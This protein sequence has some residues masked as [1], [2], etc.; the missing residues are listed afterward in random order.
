[1]TNDELRLNAIAAFKSLPNGFEVIRAKVVP[2]NG[3][4]Q[5]E[6]GLPTPLVWLNFLD[7]TQQPQ[8]LIF[9][10]DVDE[11]Q[12]VEN[13]IL[14]R[15]RSSS[16]SIENKITV[17][18]VSGLL[19]GT[20]TGVINRNYF[21]G[22]TYNH[23]QFYVLSA[24]GRL[25][26]MKNL[27]REV[28]DPYKFLS[29][30][31]AQDSLI[32]KGREDQI[33][34]L[35]LYIYEHRIVVVNGEASVGKTSLL[36]AGVIPHLLDKG[37]MA[38]KIQEYTNPV[39]VITQVL[40]SQQEGLQIPLPDTLTLPNLIH[41]ITSA[42]EGTLV[43]VLDQF[44]LLF[45]SSIS[46]EQR[47][48][49]IDELAICLREIPSQLLRL[50]IAIRSEA[51]T[52]LWE[53]QE[54][55]PELLRCQVQL[56]ALDRAN[57]A[58]A[59]REPLRVVE[60]RV[61]FYDDVVERLL[62]P[63]LAEI[64]SGDPNLIHPPYLQIV[65][66]WLYR[67]STETDPPRVIDE[68]MVN[69]AKGADGIFA[70]YLEET[71]NAIEDERRLSS[72]ML[73]L[74]ARPEVDKWVTPTQLH[75]MNSAFSHIDIEKT[76]ENLVLGGLLVRRAID[77]KYAFVNPIIAREVMRLAGP[78]A[79][80][81]S[82]AENEVERVWLSWLARNAFASGEQLRYLEEFGIDLTP[83][84]VKSMLLLRSAVERHEPPKQWLDLLNDKEGR[85]LMSQLEGFPRPA[86]MAIASEMVLTK[87]EMLLELPTATNGDSATEQ[88]SS[89]G[90]VARNAVTHADAAVRQTCALA[91]TAISDDK[92]VGLKRLTDALLAGGNLLKRRAEL[93]GALADADPVIAKLNRDLSPLDRSAIWA[94]RALRRIAQ[95]RRR[96]L[97]LVLGGALGAGVCLGIMRIG[98]AAFAYG[99]QPGIQFSMFFYY[100][101]IF[102]GSL[103]LGMSLAK[104]LL[105]REHAQRQRDV[106][107]A[108]P[109]LST[110]TT[111]LAVVLGT[112]FA[113]VAQILLLVF[114]GLSPFENPLVVPMGFA[115][116]LGLS[117][118]ISIFFQMRSRVAAWLLMIICALT[119][120]ALIQ[121]PFNIS[122]AQADA[123]SIVNTGWYYESRF[124]N[125]SWW[126][127]LAARY[128][129]LFDLIATFDSALVGM[130]LAVG[131][132]IGF[133]W[134]RKYL[135]RPAA[136]GNFTS[137]VNS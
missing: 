59:I 34:Q 4:D 16:T 85:E 114:N 49:F 23:V 108:D 72:R 46:S 123:L 64:G 2:V 134:A 31:S 21:G 107:S 32:F 42:I 78:E 74:M 20:N 15:L 48:R 53:L 95:D 116:G 104:P 61:A 13:E 98:I 105:L 63:G 50:V 1:M 100:G 8:E 115:G 56:S 76:T 9:K 38:I 58:V 101:F 103:A 110:L 27:I 133:T 67:K 119:S 25:S 80:R 91:L 82:R 127:T 79:E 131:M 68:K 135:N 44:E 137:G 26:G 70:S 71:L 65:C 14:R 33:R 29:P 40:K 87:A 37:L 96:W 28:P 124:Q 62:V 35:V 17:S 132:S 99:E 69:Q 45:E 113:G 3:T 12:W 117:L 51:R 88:S 128:S 92:T 136:I 75:E 18:S 41:A 122:A 112:A 102:G 54:R 36:A 93:R 47:N 57:A 129:N 55:L 125:Y 73:A 24:S 60:S 89:A 106:V 111:P 5:G 126:P 66:S 19:V 94:W 84:A 121:L 120:W 90:R 22:D 77:D 10:L 30:Y 52:Q 97:V 39:A 83:R 11:S 86:D 118:S 81:R 6:A 7:S 43:L 109:S 130:F